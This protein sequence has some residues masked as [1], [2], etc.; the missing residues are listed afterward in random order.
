MSLSIINQFRENYSIIT[1]HGIK[2]IYIQNFI[3]VMEL[4]CTTAKI[5][6]LGEII[7]IEGEKLQIEYL[8]KDD[9]KIS[10]IL[11]AVHMMEVSK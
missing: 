1:L 5:R 11:K 4:T 7:S 10:G 6:A 9:L 2:E 8:S 3:S